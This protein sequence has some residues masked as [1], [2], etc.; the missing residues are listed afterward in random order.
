MHSGEILSLRC[1]VLLFALLGFCAPASAA[2]PIWKIS[3][4]QQSFYL[5][6]SIHMLRHKDWP[7]PEAFD[8]T[9]AKTD[10][11]VLEADIDKMYDL[12]IQLPFMILPQGKTLRSETDPQTYRKFEDFSARLKLNLDNMER[13]KPIAV[14]LQLN[15][16]LLYKIGFRRKGPDYHYSTLAHTQSRPIDYLESVETQLEALAGTDP[17][18]ENEIISQGLESLDDE[19]KTKAQLFRLAQEWRTGEL[20]AAEKADAEM[21]AKFPRA[22]KRLLVD[23]NTAWLP[24]LDHYLETGETEFVIVGYLHLVGRNGLLAQ[25]RQRGYR[26]E[27]ID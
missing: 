6:G 15:V 17:A 27:Q 12:R 2:S 1:F 25:L 7:L 8:T 20:P 26:V 3:K 24:K 9:Y 21:R 18:T 16:K 10:M 11:L 5:A 13:F 19:A 22:Y 4:G 14:A 23:R